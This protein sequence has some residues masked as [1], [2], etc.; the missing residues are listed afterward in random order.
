[1]ITSMQN[2]GHANIQ[3]THLRLP[4]HNLFIRYLMNEKDVWQRTSEQI[5]K[6]NMMKIGI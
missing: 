4:F 6:T 2:Q 3:N 1:M 5:R